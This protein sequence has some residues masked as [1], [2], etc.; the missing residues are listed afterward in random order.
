MQFRALPPPADGDGDVEAITRKRT[1]SRM[2]ARRKFRVLASTV[3]A[4]GRFRIT[5]EV[6]AHGAEKPEQVWS[7][8]P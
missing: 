2:E 6:D 8:L 1:R 5:L 7:P 4:C 3:L